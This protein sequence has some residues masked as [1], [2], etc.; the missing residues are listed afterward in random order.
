M[1][2]LVEAR[3]FLGKAHEQRIALKIVV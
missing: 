2:M 3:Y 1:G